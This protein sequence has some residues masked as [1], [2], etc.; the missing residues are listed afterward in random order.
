M[1]KWYKNLSY[2]A[3]YMVQGLVICTVMAIC[4]VSFAY[5][6]VNSIAKEQTAVADYNTQIFLAKGD[7]DKLEA[8]LLD[9]KENA[10]PGVYQKVAKSLLEKDK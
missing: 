4:V 2:T 3:Q 5:G 9:A 8:I 7:P 1:I 10:K 6:I